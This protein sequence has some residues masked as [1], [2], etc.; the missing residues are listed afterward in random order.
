M[1]IQE[2]IS[3]GQNV[4][5]SVTPADLKEFALTVAEEV[6]ALLAKEDKPDKRLTAK[7]AA[8]QLGVTLSTL[9]RWNKVS[10]LSPAGRI[11]KKPYY[12]QSQIDAIK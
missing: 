6:K 7:D 3:S 10:Y 8:Q 4:T 1:N 9:W 12:L 2:L 5:I 11:G